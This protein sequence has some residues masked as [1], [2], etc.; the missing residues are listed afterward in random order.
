MHEPRWRRGSHWLP[1]PVLNAGL[2][3]AAATLSGAAMAQ[4]VGAQ[5]ADDRLYQDKGFYQSYV[6]GAPDAPS[7]AWLLAYGGRLYDTWWAVLL[8][9][10]PAGVHP[11]YPEGGGSGGRD[12]VETWRC[13]E[14]H[15]WDYKGRDGRY[16]SGPH[17]TGIKGVNAM[18]GAPVAR[19]AAVLRDDT[20]RYTPEMIPD[21]AL[22]ALAR[23]VSK[24]QVDTGDVID[25]ASGAVRGDAVRGHAIFQNVCAICHDF[26][27]RA[28]ITGDEDE[29]TSLGAIASRDPWRGLHK[30]MNGQTYADMP[31][32]RAFGL[33]TVLDVLAYAQSLPS[34]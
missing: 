20:H 31:A 29:L 22:E 9:D 5:S 12:A 11:A 1:R 8:Q 24:G 30:V 16:A 6:F 18:A 4:S 34:E 17:A 2:V 26:D 19:I 25:P 28:W 27:G 32:M 23:F 3:L 10:P 13:V 21:R 33:E 15:G 14:C 7:E